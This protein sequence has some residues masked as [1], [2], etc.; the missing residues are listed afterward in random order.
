MKRR[1]V[2]GQ[3]FIFGVISISVIAYAL[4]GVI[5]VSVTN[6]PFRMNLELATGGGI[7]SGSE[8]TLRGV[9]VGR[10][11]DVQLHRNG[12]TLQ[13]S[14]DHGTRIPVDSTAHIY[15]LSVVGEQ[16]VD[17]VPIHDAAPYLHQGSDVPSSRTTTPIKTATV[18]YDLEQLVSSIDP[19]AVS[20]VS[21]E[22]ATAFGNSGPQLRDII[23]SGGRLVDE[24]SQSQPQT[25]DLLNRSTTLL[26]TTIAHAADFR[27]LSDA[28]EKLSATLSSATPAAS[29]L[30]HD[31]P[32]TTSLVDQ[33]VKQ[34]AA[35]AGVLFDH[36]ATF[37]DISAANVP[38]FRALL[39]AVPETGKLIPL[40]V[41]NGAIQAAALFNYSEPV[42]SYG[43]PLPSP[44]SPTH[45]P[46]VQRSCPHVLPG[47]L[48]RGAA[49]APSSGTLVTQ[50][51]AV[52]TLGWDGGQQAVLGP[53][54]WQSLILSGTGN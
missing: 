7:F 24:L 37:S 8:V 11:T 53:N 45:A 21:S 13:L 14:I 12:V 42:C 5:G 17:F 4:F 23:V 26:N 39:V 3:L 6:R 19:H 46:L 40:V 9:H 28:L 52:S 32:A 54:S 20:T 38:A 50:S 27:T 34:N 2:L 18:L 1:T 36:L 30:L 51:G 15:D 31:S 48:V 33:L 22:L 35:A 47:E 16:Y 25:L 43:V 10:V 44:L 49:N 29:A 41:R